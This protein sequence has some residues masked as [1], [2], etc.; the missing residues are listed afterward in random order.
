[1]KYRKLITRTMFRSLDSFNITAQSKYFNESAKLR[2]LRVLVPY[3]SYALRALMPRLPRALRALLSH[4]SRAL[5][6]L[7][8]H[9]PHGPCALR[10]FVS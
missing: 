9:V 7:V 6:A 10:A 3:V 1:M 4:V 8:P 2:A 5:R